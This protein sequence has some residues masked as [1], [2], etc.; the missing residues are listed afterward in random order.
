MQSI[1]RESMPTVIVHAFLFFIGLI[2]GYCMTTLDPLIVIL[3]TGAFL[4]IALTIAWFT[5]VKPAQYIKV[6][7]FVEKH[8]VENMVKL[9]WLIENL[10]EEYVKIYKYRIR[11]I[12]DKDVASSWQDHYYD[13]FLDPKG[14]R[15]DKHDEDSF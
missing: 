1:G 13:V 8:P 15:V 3:G 12:N 5:I 11:T 10:S 2:A 9:R 6:S 4:A 7:L 14:K